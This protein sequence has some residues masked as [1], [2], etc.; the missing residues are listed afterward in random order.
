MR[1]FTFCLV[2]TAVASL[3]EIACNDTRLH[4][5]KEGYSTA[6]AHSSLSANRF[7]GENSR[8]IDFTVPGTI[9]KYSQPKYMDCWATAATIMVSWKE[10][11]AYRIEEVVSRAGT[12][13]LEIYH[14]DSG[15]DASDKPAFLAALKLRAE[16]PQTF[17]LKGWLGL[18][19]DHGLLWVT[20]IAGDDAH[21]LI[22]KGMSGDGSYDGT[23][24]SVIDPLGA[25]EYTL[26]LT[27]LIK[28]YEDLGWADL[29]YRED[30][31]PEHDLRPQVVHF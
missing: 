15:L 31:H 20:T 24:F 25:R 19:Q 17:T 6:N 18:L 11:K 1:K 2:G 8:K 7:T 27:E 29:N 21:A 16:A 30:G 13:Y 4:S 5:P 3:L 12:R 28:K 23:R 14:R 26:S 22:I 10:G 9:P